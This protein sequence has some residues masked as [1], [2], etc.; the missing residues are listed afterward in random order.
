MRILRH[1]VPV[2]LMHDKALG[3]LRGLGRSLILRCCVSARDVMSVRLFTGLR[4]RA[5]GNDAVQDLHA[6]AFYC[7]TIPACTTNCINNV[8]QL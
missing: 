7:V 1:V 4:L 6:W 2:V 5:L 8:R 3:Q